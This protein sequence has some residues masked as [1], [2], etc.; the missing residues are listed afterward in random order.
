MSFLGRLFGR[1]KGYQTVQSGSNG[2]WGPLIHEPHTGAWQEN[3]E[4]TLKDNASFYA[5][6]SCVSLIAKDIAKMPVLL[7]KWQQGVLVEADRPKKLQRVLERP[8][9]YQNWQQLQEQWTTSLLLRGNTYVYKQRD[10]FGWII[11]LV[12]L[13]PDLVKPLVDEHG[14]VFYQLS[15]DNL[16][17]S[18]SEIVPASEIIH[19]RINCFYHPLVGLTP[20]VACAA[21]SA[22]GLS[23]LENAQNFFKN[24]SRPGGILAAPGPIDKDKAQEVQNRWNQK[25]SG[26]NFGQIAVMGD[27]LKYT[28]IGISAADSQLIEQLGMSARI[29]CTAFHVPPFKVAIGDVQSGIKIGDLNEIYY[30]DCLQA[31]IEAR[32]NLLDEGLDLKSYGVQAFL[33]LDVLIRM[34]SVSQMD[35]FEKG[36][37][38]GVY[39]PN[40]VRQ[41][42]GY[43]PVK[44]GESPL[45]QQQNYSLAALAKRDAKDDPFASATKQPTDSDAKKSFS[46]AYKGVFKAEN[47]Y[48]KGEFVTNKG[49]LWH[50]EKD[51]SGEFN[52][53]NF[54][55]C[56]KEWV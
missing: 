12:V 38:M 34:D 33:D 29:V 9:N 52:H 17:Q 14:N 20:I 50:C 3:K 41:K 28:P 11:R 37:R 47:H 6:F 27:D 43:L 18:K 49:S 1:T 4:L 54:K 40:E 45:I 46:E 8:N 31:Y 23:I 13:N 39:A 22:Q 53:Q 42:L 44:G 51:C 16:S 21:A 2:G 32:E 36:I 26:N 24:S 25:Y 30:S 5:V 48:Q 15:T 56:A 10:A 35:C 19:D 55:L 7:K